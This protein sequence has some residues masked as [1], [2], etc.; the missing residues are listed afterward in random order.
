MLA[1]SNIFIYSTHPEYA[2]LIDW[3]KQHIP[4]VSPITKVETL[5]YHLLKAKDKVLLNELFEC[6]GCLYPTPFT[7]ST[8]IELRQLHK[9]TLGDSLIAATA[10]EH[11]LTLVTRNVDDFKWITSLQLVNPVID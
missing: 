2:Y 6:L 3:I 9:M 1:D 7:F 4:L 8:A 11:R 5:G 10:L